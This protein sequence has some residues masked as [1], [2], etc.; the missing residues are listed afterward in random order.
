M[1]EVLGGECGRARPDGTPLAVGSE[2]RHTPATRTSS[3]PHRSRARFIPAGNWGDARRWRPVNFIFRR[4]AENYGPPSRHADV[5]APLFQR[6]AE[7]DARTR[8]AS[9]GTN[10]SERCGG[11]FKLGPEET[12]VIGFFRREIRKWGNYAM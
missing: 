9:K 1:E 12:N 3:R 4:S 8:P 2:S 10:I 6:H 7:N 5:S 11:I